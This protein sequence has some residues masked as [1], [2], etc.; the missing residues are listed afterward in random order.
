MPTRQTG[1]LWL[2][3]SQSGKGR[4]P[5]TPK[6]GVH[7]PDFDFRRNPAN[8]FTRFNSPSSASRRPSRDEAGRHYKD[9]VTERVTVKRKTYKQVLP[10]YNKAQTQEKAQFLYLLHHSAKA[11]ESPR[12]SRDAPS[13]LEDL[14]FAMAFKSIRL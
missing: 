6:S 9:T 13:P 14:I 1:N 3:P 2:V 10:A 7:L 8:T 11:S 12:K 5:L 4:T